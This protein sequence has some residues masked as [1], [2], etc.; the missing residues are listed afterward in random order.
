ME[1]IINLALT[2]REA[3][4]LS[5]IYTLGSVLVTGNIPQAIMDAI[6]YNEALHVF[7]SKEKSLLAAK[8]TEM[9]LAVSQEA[10]DKCGMYIGTEPNA[11]DQ[12]INLIEERAKKKG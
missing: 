9:G 8:I 2:E 6:T 10:L 12:T 5:A 11:S 4:M 3:V 1:K 7:S